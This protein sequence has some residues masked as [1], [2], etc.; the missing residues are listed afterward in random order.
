MLYH[1]MDETDYAI[2]EI[3]KVDARCSYSDIAEQ[4]HLSR[5]AVRERIARMKQHGIIRGFTVV[6]DAKAYRKMAAVFLEVEV[7]PNK[8]DSVARQFTA[9]EDIAI[10][11]QHTGTSGLHMHA[12]IDGVEYLS[13]FLAD[14]IHSVDGVKG[15]QSYLLLRQY[16]MNA[17]MVRYLDED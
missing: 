1:Q 12:Y 7:E 8:L 9:H 15:V 14:H 10:V 2:L 17:Y 13:K 3:L 5:V 4:V 6:I 16:K 11:S